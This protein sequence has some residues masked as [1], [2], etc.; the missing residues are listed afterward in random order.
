MLGERVLWA[1]RPSALRTFLPSL[2]VWLFAIPWTAFALGWE[3]MALQAWLSGKGNSGTTQALF[4]IIFPL[5]GLPF[6]LIGL[7]MMSLPFFAWRWARRT[8]HVVSDQ[9]LVDITVGRRLKVKSA[10]IGS[11][12]RT[13][14]TES[15]DGRGTLKVVT[16]S[17]VDGDGDR[18]EESHTLYG[19]D[20]VRAVERL[21]GQ[22]AEG[23]RRAA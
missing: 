2:L 5:F 23:A 21:V 15:K 22:A 14:R 8:V 3:A 10:R 7:A 13:E 12:V 18:M 11:V 20:D 19:I 1:G 6:V 9:R 17:R 4:G 16:G